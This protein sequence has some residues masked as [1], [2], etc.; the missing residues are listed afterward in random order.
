MSAVQLGDEKLIFKFAFVENTGVDMPLA[1]GGTA[2]IYKE[3]S[4]QDLRA[5]GESTYPNTLTKTQMDKLVRV[6]E[7]HGTW[8]HPDAKVVLASTTHCLTLNF[9]SV[10]IIDD[11]SV[12]RGVQDTAAI[13]RGPTWS[14]KS[15]WYNKQVVLRAFLSNQL[16]PFVAAISCI[17]QTQLPPLVSKT[18]RMKATS[19]PCTYYTVGIQGAIAGTREWQRQYHEDIQ[20]GDVMKA[21]RNHY[22]WTMKKELKAH[23]GVI[24]VIGDS[25]KTVD[26]ERGW[27]LKTLWPASFCSKLDATCLNAKRDAFS[28]SSTSPPSSSTVPLPPAEKKSRISYHCEHAYVGFLN[29][30]KTN[31]NQYDLK[32]TRVET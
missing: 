32:Q 16:P 25:D 7:R 19:L 14:N 18:V 13:F 2:Q 17:V 30:N 8:M 4:I 22:A 10:F 26:Q 23:A 3:V 12:P 9:E 31:P 11:Q 20:L 24:F 29:I 27:M 28:C 15:P 5:G 21:Y 1:F 6:F